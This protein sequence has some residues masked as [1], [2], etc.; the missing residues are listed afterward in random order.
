MSSQRYK[1]VVVRIKLVHI[2]QGLGIFL[3]QSKFYTRVA[4]ITISVLS[5]QLSAILKIN[6]DFLNENHNSKGI[7]SPGK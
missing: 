2:L 1:V 5:A 7:L 4:L 6:K 3:A